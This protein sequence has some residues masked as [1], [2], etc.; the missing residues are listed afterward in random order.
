MDVILLERVPNLG[1][2]GDIVSVKPGYARN[3]LLPQGK[4]LRATNE[5]KKAFE[6]RRAQ[7]ET[8]N[9]KKRHEAE[10]V[11]KKMDAI[12]VNVIRQ[13]AEGGHLYG[14]VSARDI[15]IAVTESGFTIERQQVRLNQTIKMLGLYPMEIA[16]HPEVSVVVTV[17]VA[18]SEDEAKTQWEK[19]VALV[20]QPEEKIPAEEETLVEV[21]EVVSDDKV[22]TEA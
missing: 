1:Q 2:M 17:N 7:L 6:T 10:A 20:S 4:A 18:R 8:V 14:S 16:L 15:E 22:E 3:Y 21:I 9:L 13:A 19:G 12:V 5:S 11:A